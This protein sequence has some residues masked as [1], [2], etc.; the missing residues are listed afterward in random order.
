MDKKC[1]KTRSMQ[2]KN[3]CILLILTFFFSEGVIFIY[4]VCDKVRKA[5]FYFKLKSEI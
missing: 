2:E 5:I 4:L 3:K 1:Q